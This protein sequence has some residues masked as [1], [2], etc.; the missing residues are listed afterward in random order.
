MLP[1]L[2]SRVADSG[3]A[4]KYSDE[5]LQAIQRLERK[6]GKMNAWKAV[7]RGALIG[8]ITA[9]IG[10]GYKESAVDAWL[11]S[12]TAQKEVASVFEATRDS[13]TYW[14]RFTGWGKNQTRLLLAKDFSLLRGLMALRCTLERTRFLEACQNILEQLLIF[15]LVCQAQRLAV[16]VRL[17][18]LR[19]G[20]AQVFGYHEEER[21]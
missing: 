8:L 7:K 10:V 21:I 18:V 1:R 5:Q 15:R 13:R 11:M 17:Q 20:L 19:P 2:P 12:K 3:G 9:A 4:P 16:L 6:L 14:E